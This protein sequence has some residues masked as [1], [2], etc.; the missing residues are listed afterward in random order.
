M[1]ERFDADTIRV[2]IL[3]A[4]GDDPF[5]VGEPVKPLAV[6]PK[7]VGLLLSEDDLRAQTCR[8]HVDGYCGSRWNKAA[9]CRSLRGWSSCS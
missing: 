5:G 7:P 1:S 4:A 9:R 6:D 8:G 2:R 3:D